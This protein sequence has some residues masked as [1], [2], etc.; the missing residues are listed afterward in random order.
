MRKIRGWNHRKRSG[1][2]YA[3]VID[4]MRRFGKRAEYLRNAELMFSKAKAELQEV[5]QRQWAFNDLSL[6]MR[7]L[8]PPVRLLELEKIDAV[9]SKRV[10]QLLA[11][12]DISTRL[13]EDVAGAAATPDLPVFWLS[14]ALSYVA[15][16]KEIELVDAVNQL[17]ALLELILE[18]APRPE[19]LTARLHLLD[20]KL[21]HISARTNSGAGEKTTATF[22]GKV[23]SQC[24]G[25]ILG[26]V[27]VQTLS[28]AQP[29]FPKIDFDS[30]SARHGLRSV[31][32]SDG[33]SIELPSKM[34]DDIDLHN[35]M[36]EL[37]PEQFARNSIRFPWETS[38][39]RAR[40]P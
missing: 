15:K 17:Q 20:E 9:L 11:D 40:S 38:P 29:D 2:T 34:L 7:S 12:F 37:C 25:W 32:P 14:R 1:C 21:V 4:D 22:S 5:S 6:T 19:S 27:Y 39:P 36:I 10:D 33:V 18:V 31:W 13:I 35:A 24:T 16:P 3:K 26:P 23:V 8:P 28:A 30:Y